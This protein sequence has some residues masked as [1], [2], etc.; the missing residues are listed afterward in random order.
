MSAKTI[1]YIMDRSVQLRSTT[2]IRRWKLFEDHEIRL[3]HSM[4]TT[5]MA[6]DCA[7]TKRLEG[8]LGFAL[9]IKECHLSVQAICS[10]GEMDRILSIF[11][12]WKKTLTF[13]VNR[14]GI[15]KYSSHVLCR[16]LNQHNEH[17][18]VKLQKESKQE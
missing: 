15:Y 12:V 10:I 5:I 8:V 7:K 17:P 13:R 11:Y 9:F 2:C 16:W 1:T 6:E 18:L 4:W 3:L 14:I